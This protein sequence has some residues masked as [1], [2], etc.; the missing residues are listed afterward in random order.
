ML[1]VT[2]YEIFISLAMLLFDIELLSCGSECNLLFCY[3]ENKDHSKQG[4][5]SYVF[6]AL[7]LIK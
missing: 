4:L 7:L 2:S 3:I 6:S 5:V 1:R